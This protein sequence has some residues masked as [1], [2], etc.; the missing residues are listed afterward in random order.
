MER[1]K[2]M[3]S[4]LRSH[5]LASK[6]ASSSRVA[7]LRLT[8]A[9]SKFCEKKVQKSFIKHLGDGFEMDSVCKKKNKNM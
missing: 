2:R 1:R 8:V 4:L 3:R 7:R 6:A 9:L 5:L